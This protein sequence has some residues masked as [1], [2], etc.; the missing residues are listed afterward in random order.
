VLGSSTIGPSST[1]H[2]LLRVLAQK[3]GQTGTTITCTPSGETTDLPM[4]KRASYLEALLTAPSSLRV[5][6]VSSTVSEVS[7]QLQ[8]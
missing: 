7:R 2:L 3:V 1:P 8:W 4:E 6:H 5:P